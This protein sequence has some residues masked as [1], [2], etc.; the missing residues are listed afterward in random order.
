ME[1]AAFCHAQIRI[2]HDRCHIDIMTTYTYQHLL[3]FYTL[4]AVKAEVSNDE[5]DC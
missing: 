3:M 4:K 5:R 2:E 1:I